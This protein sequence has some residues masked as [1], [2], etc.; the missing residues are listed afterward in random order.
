M[1]LHFL[2]P[3]TSPRGLCCPFCS[4]LRVSTRALCNPKYHPPNSGIQQ[5]GFINSRISKV[6]ESLQK[7][8]NLVFSS[9]SHPYARS[10][11]ALFL[12]LPSLWSLHYLWQLSRC[13]IQHQDVLVCLLGK[14]LLWVWSLCWGRGYEEICCHKPGS[15]QLP[16][17]SPCSTYLSA[18]HRPTNPAAIIA[19]NV[20][21]GKF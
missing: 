10:L 19:V 17:S 8:I 20:R 15:Q 3:I 9:C 14:A 1:F 4:V 6:L 16:S 5:N 13:G 21:Y 7:E 18:L 2:A 11:W 12:Q